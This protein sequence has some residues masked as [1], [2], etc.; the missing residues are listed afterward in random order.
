[1]VTSH[2][3]W[4]LVPVVI[5][6]AA[7]AAGQE[8]SGKGSL[9]G[10]VVSASGDAP[11]VGA[12]VQ[13]D[14]TEWRAIA[15][16]DGRFELDSVDPGT[17][18]LHVKAIGYEEGDWRLSLHPNHVTKH[19]FP[20]TPQA[21][22]LPG[23]AVHGKTPLSARRFL[24]FERRRATASGAFLTQEDIEKANPSSLV[25]ILVT[26]RG[27]QQ[28]C[29]VND[30]IAKMVRSPPGCYPQYYIDGIE[31]SAYFARHTPPRDIRGVEIY[32]GASEI[33]GEFGGSSSACGVIAIW[34][35]SSP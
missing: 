19:S 18:V 7:P 28:V 2:L 17:Y 22:E 32:R 27:V 9:V 8:P 25:D 6:L 35:K 15:D 4:F 16:S 24:D 10:F 14:T 12:T 21:I 26:V 23:V 3:P 34:T 33:P 1:M 13:L 29:L 11:I 31:S 30:C 20:L 5:G